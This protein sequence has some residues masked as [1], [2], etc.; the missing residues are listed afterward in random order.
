MKYVVKPLK[1]ICTVI[2]C[3]SI[4]SSCHKTDTVQ[5][6]PVNTGNSSASADSL[7]DHLQFVNAKK[8]QGTIPAGAQASSLKISF[9]DTLYLTDQVKMPVKFLH[10]DT[11]Q[12]VAG[13]YIQVQGLIGGSFASY[14]YDVPEVQELDSSDTV[15]VIMIGIDPTDLQVPLSFNVTI[16]PY[17]DEHH[18]IKQTDETIEVVKHTS[19]PKGKGGCGLDNRLNETWDWVMSYMEKSD[20]TSTPEKIWGA[21]GQ[22]ILGSCCDGNISIYGTCPGVRLPNRSLHF[23]TFYQIAGEQITF[24]DGGQFDRRTVERG[25]NPLPD[26]SNFCDP[27]EGRVRTY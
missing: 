7:S 11:T 27:F 21:D 2:A 15:S 22:D 12:N 4:I 20:F 10:E 16:T 18:P 3:S 25:A 19:D 9:K 17:D 1:F 8:I 5:P 26:S 14:Y 24:Y 13:I 23:N 6:P